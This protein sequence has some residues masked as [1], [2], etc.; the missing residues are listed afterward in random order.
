MEV[1]EPEQFPDPL[2]VPAKPLRPD[3]RRAE[4][5]IAFKN[6]ANAEFLARQEKTKRLREARIQIEAAITR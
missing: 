4:T 1:K 6:I 5:D 3:A 2:D